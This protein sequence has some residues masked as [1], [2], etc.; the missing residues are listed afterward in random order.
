MIF[1]YC[2]DKFVAIRCHFEISIVID[3]KIIGIKLLQ[4]FL[5]FKLLQKNFLM[6]FNINAF[7][8]IKNYKLLQLVIVNVIIYN[9]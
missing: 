9:F 3:C 1:S 4:Q 5:Q 6:Q 2:N 8:V 7:I